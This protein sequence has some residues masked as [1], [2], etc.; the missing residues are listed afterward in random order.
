MSDENK[1]K[2][3]LSFAFEILKKLIDW[4]FRR[5]QNQQVDQQQ[6]QN[7]QNVQNEEGKVDGEHQE[8]DNQPSDVSTTPDGGLSFDEFNKGENTDEKEKKK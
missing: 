8:I 4:F 1:K 2:S 5:K 6:Q 7:Q 3:W